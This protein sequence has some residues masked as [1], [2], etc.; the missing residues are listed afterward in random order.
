MNGDPGQALGQCAPWGSANLSVY[1]LVNFKQTACLK[2]QSRHRPALVNRVSQGAVE[3]RDLGVKVQRS[4]RL[5]PL[6]GKA[7]GE[8]QRVLFR[9]RH[10]EVAIREAPR[11]LDEP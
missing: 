6:A 10:V 5:E 3:H 8:G 1:H 7:R 2:L 9:D 11:E 4:Q